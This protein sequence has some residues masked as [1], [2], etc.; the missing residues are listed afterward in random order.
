ME[1]VFSFKLISM[2]TRKIK[3]F[4]NLK[5]NEYFHESNNGEYQKIIS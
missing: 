1:N 5:N 4:Y 3:I 2:L